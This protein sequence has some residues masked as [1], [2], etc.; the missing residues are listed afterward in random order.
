MAG[1]AFQANICA[2]AGNGPLVAAA[3]MRF[4]QPEDSLKLQ[5]GQHDGFSLTGLY[6][7]GNVINYALV[8]TNYGEKQCL[9]KNFTLSKSPD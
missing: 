9:N 3:R 7:K 1:I 5:I 4:S 2:Q 8:R 6:R